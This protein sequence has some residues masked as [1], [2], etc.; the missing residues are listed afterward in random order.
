[1]FKFATII[2]VRFVIAELRPIALHL[3][4]VLVVRVFMLIF[5]VFI[6]LV[7]VYF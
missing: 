7:E 3:M 6:V 5:I 4:Q 1:L 2:V